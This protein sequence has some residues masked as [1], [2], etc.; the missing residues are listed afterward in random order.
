[1]NIMGSFECQGSQTFTRQGTNVWGCQVAE[2]NLPPPGLL[3]FPKIKLFH[4]NSGTTSYA[5]EV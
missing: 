4:T 5:T 1:M 3:D 2:G